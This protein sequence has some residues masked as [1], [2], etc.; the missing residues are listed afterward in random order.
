MNKVKIIVFLLA[1]GLAGSMI[2]YAYLSYTKV[3]GTDDKLKAEIHV[4]QVNK[5][6]MPDPGIKRFEGATEQLRSGDKEGGRIA[7]YEL[8]R[9]F[10]TSKCVPETKRIIGELN[11]DA[12]FS[13]DDNPVKKDYIVQPGDSLGLIARKNQTTIECILRANSMLSM[14]LQPGDNLVVLPLEFE[15]IVDISGKTVTL[16]RNKSFFKEYPTIDIKL[17]VGMKAPTDT[18]TISDKAA[19]VRGKRVLST[20]SDFM[21][22]DKWLMSS[23]PGFNIRAQAQAKPV[24]DSIHVVAPAK[25]S[26]KAPAPP[27]NAPAKKPEPGKPSMAVAA[28]NDDHDATANIPQTG[29]FLAREDAE[30][31]YTLIRTQTPVK[32]LR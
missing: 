8:L 15:M 26:V 25:S 14:G 1:V 13:V 16:L 20:D 6:D 18:I 5:K 24:D 19:W 31:L 28:D 22:A 2:T 27:K 32:V 23:K 17:P 30:E 21:S 4:M 11:M 7:L 9:Q 29:V 3:V 12:L 10:P